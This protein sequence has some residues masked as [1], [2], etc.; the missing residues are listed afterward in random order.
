[1]KIV[2]CLFA[3][4]ALLGSCS[5]TYHEHAVKGEETIE[6]KVPPDADEF[7]FVVFREYFECD[8]DT[9]CYARHL[10]LEKGLGYD[11]VYA[12]LFFSYHSGLS[13]ARLY[14]KYESAARDLSVLGHQLRVSPYLLVPQIGDTTEAPAP[15]ASLYSYRRKRQLDYQYITTDQIRHLIVLKLLADYVHIQPENV[16]DRMADGEI[17]IVMLAKEWKRAGT[18]C[19]VSQRKAVKS[20]RPWLLPQEKRDKFNS[21]IKERLQEVAE[22]PPQSVPGKKK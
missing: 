5:S 3:V 15:L 11:T 12:L 9:A 4:V 7:A 16:F 13:L 1:M 18:G 19:S 17:P 10:A 2:F 21:A 20:E 14:E 22:N 8:Y 6:V